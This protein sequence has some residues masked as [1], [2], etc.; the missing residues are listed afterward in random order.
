MI[1][2]DHNATTPISPPVLQTMMPFFQENF[3]NASSF[4]RAG[5]IARAGLEEA[6]ACIAA[7]IRSSPEEIVFTGSG[8]EADNLAIRGVCRAFCGRRCHIVTSSIEHHAVLKT[9]EDLEEQG[10]AVTRLPVDSRGVV[11]PDQ[12]LQSLT[13]DTVLI[14]IM[15]ANNETGVLQPIEAISGI[16]R[17][18]GILFHT[19]AVQ[20]FG[21]VPVNV[22]DLDIDLMTLSAHK[23]Y[24]PKGVGALYVRK[25]SAI[26]PVL[27]GGSHERGKRAGTE[28]I[29]AI[30]GFAKAAE[31]AG[32]NLA[33]DAVNMAALR[34]AFEEQVMQRIAQVRVNGRDAPRVPNTSSMSFA[35]V[36][37]ESILLHLDLKGICASTGSACATGSAQPSHVMRAMGLSPM[38]AQSTIRFSLGRDT[39]QGDLDFTVR[40]LADAI[41]KLRH[42]SSTA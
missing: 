25:G 6:R 10:T 41:S 13:P 42:I 23:I 17:S 39:S 9:C 18:R 20:A 37:G 21:K 7:V 15:A 40:V 2:L 4:C 22:D 11:D 16:A 8:T 19:D 26:A 1:Y 3:G 35:S 27:T 24:G 29:A 5:R 31:L 32:K 28:N 14:S 30:A 38:D 34:D 12:V 33:E 36:D